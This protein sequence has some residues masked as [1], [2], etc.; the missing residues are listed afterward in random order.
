M[1]ISYIN[2]KALEKDVEK[3]LKTF[4]EAYADTAANEI[5]KFA[6]Q[7]IQRFYDHYTPKYYDRTDDLKKNSFSKYKHNNGRQ[8][9]GGVRISTHNMS[10]YVVGGLNNR[11]FIDPFYIARPAWEKGIH[12]SENGINGRYSAHRDAIPPLEVLQKEVDKLQFRKKIEN[13]A[14]NAAKKQQYQFLRFK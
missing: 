4:A 13:I 7:A 2:K 12:G 11:R 10:P 6:Q 5:T 14:R 3:Y 9:Y 1:A 8:Y